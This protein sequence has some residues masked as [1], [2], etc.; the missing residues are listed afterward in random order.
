MKTTLCHKH[1]CY[2]SALAGYHY[3]QTHIKMEQSWGQRRIQRK[4]STQWHHLYNSNK[5]RVAKNEFLK[6]YPYC[7]VC[8]ALATVVD[9]VVPHRGNEDL[10]WD[11]NNWQPLCT[12]HHGAK[13]MKENNFFKKNI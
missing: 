9:H 1:G 6:R 2:A 3:C 13:T 7:V 5:W 10:F 8:G 12:A 11:E 4:Q